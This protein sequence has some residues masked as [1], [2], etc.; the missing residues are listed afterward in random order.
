[1]APLDEGQKTEIREMIRQ[2]TKEAFAASSAQLA[3][4]KA[5]MVKGHTDMRTTDMVKGH[6]DMRTMTE[7]F[8]NH[9]LASNT[10]VDKKYIELTQDIE[11]G[12]TSLLMELGKEFESTKSHAIEV[13]ALDAGFEGQKQVMISVI[14]A[15]FKDF[16]TKSD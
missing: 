15:H 4:E 14:N 7:E 8:V 9:Q 12:F 1:M 5:D 10:E 3:I 13:C 11:L 16:E 6:T 2:G